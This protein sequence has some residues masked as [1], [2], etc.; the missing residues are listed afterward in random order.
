MT[1]VV[2]IGQSSIKN[3]Y[4]IRFVRL[5][6]TSLH[7]NIPP[8]PLLSR[9]G[10]QQLGAFLRAQPGSRAINKFI[11]LKLIKFSISKVDFKYNGI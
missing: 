4:I 7:A 6:A 5:P 1:K 11:K 8:T 3:E 9:V 2:K 10:Q